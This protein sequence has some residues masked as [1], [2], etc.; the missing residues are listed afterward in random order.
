[1]GRKTDTDRI[2]HYILADSL[3]YIQPEIKLPKKSI[4]KEQFTYY[5]EIYDRY[6]LIEL[7]DHVIDT[8]AD[9]VIASNYNIEPDSIKD[10]LEKVLDVLEEYVSLKNPPD[11][12]AMLDIILKYKMNVNN[13]VDD[14]Y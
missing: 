2:A 7:I 14:M 8:I 13:I 3:E 11:K 9:I 6:T 12:D 1:M 10:V 5:A 4:T